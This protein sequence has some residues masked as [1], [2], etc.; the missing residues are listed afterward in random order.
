MSAIDP[1]T[2]SPQAGGPLAGV[3]V[4]ELGTLIAG[5]FAARFMGEFG[6]DV[7][8]NRRPARRRPA[9]Q[10]AQAVSRRGRYVAVVGRA[11]AQ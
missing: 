1:T 9:A 4:L 3:K 2:Q 7:I 11:G 5:P 8:K 10:M 6:A